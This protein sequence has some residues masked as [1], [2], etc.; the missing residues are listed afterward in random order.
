MLFFSKQNM[1]FVLKTSRTLLQIWIFL[2][3]TK[4][5]KITKVNTTI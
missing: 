4:W 1:L 5:L 2:P 3:T